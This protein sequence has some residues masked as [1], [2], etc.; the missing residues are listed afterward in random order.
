M[1]EFSLEGYKSY[2]LAT[3]GVVFTMDM[4]IELEKDNV[5][6]KDVFF[7]VEKMPEYPGGEMEL[8]KFIAMNMNY[9]EEAR[10]QKAEGVVIVRFV[11]TAKGNIEF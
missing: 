1:L 9:P 6:D 8:K 7:V 3:S 2:Y 10:D 5:P 11:V 4:Q